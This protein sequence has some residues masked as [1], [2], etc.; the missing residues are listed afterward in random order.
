[1][2]TKQTT[3]SERLAYLY[4]A[5]QDA[6]GLICM[7]EQLASAAREA[8]KEIADAIKALKVS[9]S[10]L[11]SVLDGT[12]DNLRKHADRFE[13]ADMTVPNLARTCAGFIER[14]LKG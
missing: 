2:P 9:G 12:A 4:K 1:M 14:A 3:E 7:L 8:D 5:Q 10:M 6:R 11:P 13:S